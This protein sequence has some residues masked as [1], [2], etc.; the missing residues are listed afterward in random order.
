MTYSVLVKVFAGDNWYEFSLLRGNDVPHDQG[1]SYGLADPLT[2]TQRI[3]DSPLGILAHPEPDEATFALIAPDSS[4][5]ADIQL[6]HGV[7]ITIYPVNDLAGTPVATFN[8]RIAGLQGDPHPLGILLTFSCVDYTA[9]LAEI[10]VGAVNYPVEGVDVR[11]ARVLAE[12]GVPVPSPLFYPA[13]FAGGLS[14]KVAA[15]TASL[16]DL[17]SMLRELLDAATARAWRYPDDGSA[18]PNGSPAHTASYRAYVVPNLT[19]DY[20]L[21]PVTP[22]R[23]RIASQWSRRVKY[24]PPARVTNVGGTY[25]VTVDAANSSPSSGAPIISAA[26]VEFAPTFTQL[27]GGGLPN[28]TRGADAQGNVYEWDW[29]VQSGWATGGGTLLGNRLVPYGAGSQLDPQGPP[30]A[31]EFTLPALD[32]TDAGAGPS[33]S[34]AVMDYRVPFRPGSLAAWAVGTMSWQV[35]AEPTVVYSWDGTPNASTSTKRTGT[36]VGTLERNL[37]T[38]PAGFGGGTAMGFTANVGTC[39]LDATH[40]WASFAVPIKVPAPSQENWGYLNVSPSAGGTVFNGTK[41]P[42]LVAGRT[43]T[44]SCVV[45]SDTAQSLMAIQYG[46]N[47][48][49]GAPV[50]VP[51]N[52]WWGLQVTWVEGVNAY[53]SVRRADRTPLVGNLWIAALMIQETANL[54][55]GWWAPGNPISPDVSPVRPDLTQLLTVAGAQVGKLPNAREWVTGMVQGT[56]FKLA[57]G[58][59]TMDLDLMP[60]SLDYVANREQLGSSLGVASLDSPA[61]SGVTLAQLA[62]RD[63]LGD[64]M[65][66][67]GS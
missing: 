58:R 17:Y 26:R 11:L 41:L 21:D 27:K 37:V 51:A 7:A 23:F 64:Y 28:V 42:T 19:V 20:Q 67:R 47:P 29:R 15:R 14:T 44:F 46:D 3:A 34:A 18:F 5:Y 56:V 61:L 45:M 2:I 24:A 59:A 52:Q 9:D 6:G 48:A 53:L 65:T 40:M 13:A 1:A 60:N 12:A 43:Y 63:T 10:Q 16:T 39:D 25:T 36:G 57:K 33:P 22:F 31:Q 55:P 54:T 62:A 4:T 8:G 66:V 35:W 50:A 49:N 38:D 30:I 32:V